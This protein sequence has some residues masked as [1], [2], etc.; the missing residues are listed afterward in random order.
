MNLEHNFANLVG[1]LSSSDM[2]LCL[3]FLFSCELNYAFHLRNVYN[4]AFVVQYPPSSWC[5][6]YTL[7]SILHDSN[8][9]VEVL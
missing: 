5:H 7:G 8:V 6:E 4:Q 9:Q 3:E 2:M 1:I